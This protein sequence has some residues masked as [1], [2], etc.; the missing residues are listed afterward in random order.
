MRLLH[1]AMQISYPT[2]L[3]AP[4]STPRH[5]ALPQRQKRRQDARWSRENR[6]WWTKKH[7]LSKRYAR[8][9]LPLWVKRW[10]SRR[11]PLWTRK[12]LRWL[13]FCRFRLF[14]WWD[15]EEGRPWAEWLRCLSMLLSLTNKIQL[16]SSAHHKAL[17]FTK[18]SFYYT[19]FR[20][21]YC[22]QLF[23]PNNIGLIKATIRLIN[24]SVVSYNVD[25]LKLIV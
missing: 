18:L 2:I 19:L 22:L 4:I 23:W 13:R 21:F 9:L 6:S 3:C 20:L 11:E 7:F 25:S 5:S 1:S 10:R 15:G 14:A 17:P 24:N 12:N 8:G 16:Q